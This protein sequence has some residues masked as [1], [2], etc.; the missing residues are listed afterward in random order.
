MVVTRRNSRG[1]KSDSASHDIQGATC[2]VAE[3]N[4]ASTRAKYALSDMDKA[5]CGRQTINYHSRNR[6]VDIFINNHGHS[7]IK[8][9]N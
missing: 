9:V 2:A 4:Q 5:V 3:F 8:L 7:S 6:I 1:Y